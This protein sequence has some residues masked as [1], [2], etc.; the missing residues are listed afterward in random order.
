M[1]KKIFFGI[2]NTCI[3]KIIIVLIMFNLFFSFFAK[4]LQINFLNKRTETI[5]Q[6]QK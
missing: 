1:K 4:N 3:D 2:I 6:T 5:A